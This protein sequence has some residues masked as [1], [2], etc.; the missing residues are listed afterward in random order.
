MRVPRLL[1]LTAS[2]AGC[3]AMPAH[4]AAP[5]Q[6][7]RFQ[8]IG[9]YSAGELW[10]RLADVARSNDP[11]AANLRDDEA[12]IVVLDT[13]SGEIRQCGN[14]SGHCIRMNPWAAARSRPASV[15]E[16]QAD[17]DRAA[18]EEAAARDAELPDAVANASGR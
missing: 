3:G 17:L 7:G 5:D 18:E 15:T 11:Q 1:A 8:G 10:E 14:L 2:L 12:I 13:H 9:I 4:N 6:G 16:H